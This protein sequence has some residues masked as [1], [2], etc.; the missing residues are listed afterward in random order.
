MLLRPKNEQRSSEPLA[1]S[2]RAKCGRRYRSR[3]PGDGFEALTYGYDAA[4]RR[5]SMTLPG[6]REVTYD[7]DTAGLLDTITDW[8]SRWASFTYDDAGRRETATRSNGVT[9]TYAYDNAGQVESIVHANG[10]STLQSFAYTYDD[11]GNR[12][13]LTSPQGNESYTYDAV[14]RLTEAS[15][16]TLTVG[17]TYDAAGNRTSETRGAQTTNYTYDDA[18]QLTQVG[19]ET[20]TYDEAGNLTNAGSD[21][22]DWDNAN[23]LTSVSKD[24]H[25]ATY[26]YDGA[27]VKTESTVDSDT[28]ELLV[29]R[30]SGLPTLVDDGERAYVHGGG[31]AWQ[32][33]AS[34][35]E[36]ALQDGLGS[37]RGLAGSSGSPAG[38]ASFEAFGARR[39]SSGTTSVFGFAGEPMD[40]TGFVDL[41]A[42]ALDPGIGRFLSI[43]TVRP[44][45][46][47]GQGYNLYSYVANNPATWIDPSGHYAQVL[48]LGQQ[49]AA[50]L[51]V[52]LTPT[53]LLIALVAVAVF[54]LLIC[55]LMDDCREWFFVGR[56]GSLENPQRVRNDQ[57]GHA[58]QVHP[59][60][61]PI[62]GPFDLPGGDDDSPE[63]GQII[64]RV[65]GGASSPLGVSWTP[66]DPRLVQSDPDLRAQWGRY[67]YRA[68]A[69]L[70]DSNS[71]SYLIKAILKNPSAV[72]PGLAVR[73]Q[74][75]LDP[76]GEWP[77]GLPEYLFVRPPMPGIDIDVVEQDIPLVPHY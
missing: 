31:L 58:D 11:A 59:S 39:T 74:T 60:P 40:G 76:V 22:Y 9:S 25:S 26:A 49:I 43:D 56:S 46:P 30:V 19:S 13:G 71:G 67:A 66:V 72:V 44:N 28:D 32:T 70:P 48:T 63:P 65:Y 4:G 47:G 73:V 38:S 14:D 15:Y 64:Y 37:V 77:G 16:P 24:G 8:G 10:G 2:V 36:F 35:T 68:F 3:A 33:S 21:T 52:L 5:T 12:T 29:D 75:K 20:Y 1:R 7:Y 51:G 6:S 45:A 55:A 41:R 54:A 62:P 23:R 17:Y 18:S 57:A 61:V 69:G 42:R 34:S 53:G 50:A 27:G